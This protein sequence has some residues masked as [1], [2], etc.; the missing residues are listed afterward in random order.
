MLPIKFVVNL[1]RIFSP[2][3]CISADLLFISNGD[4]SLLCRALHVIVS[5]SVYSQ[6]AIHIELS[7][8]LDY[9]IA[10]LRKFPYTQWNKNLSPSYL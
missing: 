3:K 4:L 1:K 10:T 5:P 2:L 8:K 6:N 7:T 9:I